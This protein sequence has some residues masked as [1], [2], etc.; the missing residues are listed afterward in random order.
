LI[1]TNTERKK[2]WQLIAASLYLGIPNVIFGIYLSPFGLIAS[3]AALSYILWIVCQKENSED[4]QVNRHTP[5]LLLLIICT[6]W[7]F[8]SGMTGQIYSNP[9][10]PVRL[11]L[12]N[13]LTT[14]HWPVT[15][16]NQGDY[17]FLRA[18]IGY[19]L[20]SALIGKAFG[21]YAIALWSLFFWSVIGVYLTLSIALK[22]YTTH[23]ALM[24]AA[25]IIFFSGL[26]VIGYLIRHGGVLHLGD[27]ME[28]WAG[29]WQYSSNTT[30]LFWVPNHAISAWL[31]TAL[32]MR[33]SEDSL[34]WN[35]SPLLLAM[36]LTFSPL[37]FMGS[38]AL[39][40]IYFYKKI[41]QSIRY[42]RLYQISAAIALILFL[43]GASFILRDA[44][45][46]A[47]PL[48][49]NHHSFLLLT[50]GYHCFLLLE[51]GI[52]AALISP[53]VIKN[54]FLSSPAFF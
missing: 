17:Y 39:Y 36:T 32:M 26:D 51:F 38:A 14:I 11:T 29:R 12:L 13:D 21:S 4:N 23:I 10:W 30:L 52:L 50:S 15:Y 48:H 33:K 6:A 18:P 3:V 34:F 37:S 41:I 42:N 53:F 20:P 31:F 8:S 49:T 35:A 2:D 45:S 16:Q 43:I 5:Q 47:K 44:S 54:V 40:C 46:I 19:Y 7:V 25:V 27:H 1:T 28:W 9:D 22:Q 24:G